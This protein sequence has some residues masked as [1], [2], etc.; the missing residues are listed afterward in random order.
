MIRYR[1][2]ALVTGLIFATAI[3]GQYS[4]FNLSQYKL[5][6][7]KLNK[8]DFNFDLYH[9]KDNNITQQSLLDERKSIV[10]NFS[11]SLNLTYFHY[12][13]TEKYQG[14]LTAGISSQ[15][16]IY[17]NRL[18]GLQSTDNSLSTGLSVYST[19]RFFNLKQFFLEVDPLLK[20]NFLIMKAHD[21]PTS[22]FA[23]DERYHNYSTTISAPVSIGH[24]RIEPVEDARLAIYILEELN[25]AGRIS[26]LPPDNVV[27]EMAKEI[28]KI[29]NKRFFDSRLRKIEELQTI[30]SFLVANNIISVHDISYFAVLNDQWDYASGPVRETGFAISAGFDNNILLSRTNTETTSTGNGIIKNESVSNS[31]ELGGFLRIRYAKPVNLYWQNSLDVKTSLGRNFYRD[32]NDKSNPLQ[33]FESNIFSMDL[34][35]SWQFLPNSRTSVQMSLQGIY[36]YSFS[37]HNSGASTEVY[38]STDNHVSFLPAINIYYYISPQMR[39][40]LASSFAIS[41]SNNITKFDNG[42]PDIKTTLNNYHHSISL[43]FVYSFF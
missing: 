42:D 32:P 37:D 27:I 5:P 1:I 25:K 30:D 29:K 17:T 41:S 22:T 19:N 8:L 15:P 13:N 39:L 31:Y 33:N 23:T 3:N 43:Q 7:I 6:D 18:D 21:E 38:H 14:D 28:S 2:S 11:G 4:G 34:S 40:Q 26:A 12:R 9:V 24:G 36:D 16:S 10:N 35:Y 20:E